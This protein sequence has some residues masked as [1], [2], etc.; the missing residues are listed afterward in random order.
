MS[1]PL[2]PRSSGI[3]SGNLPGDPRR[4]RSEAFRSA[5]ATRLNRRPRSPRR[6]SPRPQER[7]GLF[8]FLK[9]PVLHKPPPEPPLDAQVPARDVVV[10][11]R[12]DLHDLVVLH[13]E[14]EGATDSAVGAD[15]VGLGLLRL[16]PG[17]GAAHVVFALEHQRA[18]GAD[19]DAVAAVDAG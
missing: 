5:A 3:R 18:G 1:R 19:A 7:P 9:V 16:V 13:A 12:R 14:L 6:T 8:P 10:Q 17:A 2:A 11:R 15:G 4:A